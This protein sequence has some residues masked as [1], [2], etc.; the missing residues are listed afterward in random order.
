MSSRV[1]YNN[2]MF[3]F[4]K[5]K[6]KEE[7]TI[8]VLVVNSYSVM[9]AVVRTYHR[10][11]AVAKPI[12]LFSCEEK[13]P[14]HRAS[15]SPWGR[16]GEGM[17][18]IESEI[19]KAL[20]KCRKVHGNYDKLV[21]VIGEPWV[22]N[23]TR[24]M[25][26]EKPKAFKLTQKTIDELL[27]RDARLFEQEALRDYAKEQEWG[28]MYHAQPTVLINGYPA[29]HPV[30][31]VAKS[32]ELHT[33]ISLAPAEVIDSIVEAYADVFHRTDVLFLGTGDILSKFAKHQKNMGVITLGGVSSTCSLFHQGFLD[34]SETIGSGLVEVEESIAY[35]FGVHQSHI[36]SVLRFASDEKLLEHERDVYYKRIEAAYKN[37]SNEI[38]RGMLRIKKQIGSIPGHLW[39][40]ASPSW[41]AILQP[42]IEKDIGVS[43]IIP[44]TEMFNDALIYSHEARIKNAPLALAILAALEK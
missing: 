5:N 20:E 13:I 21:C 26:I 36:T 41:I 42:R 31:M 23:K 28:V 37:L 18:L 19:K 17:N 38:Q 3:S 30:G 27:E 6:P 15:P 44:N 7:R 9:A 34:H 22:M 11:G 10:E 40:L 32:V 35:L 12:V 25:S 29:M 2:Y 14:H 43:V 39:L 33:T 8:C 16:A 24:H 4:L 1:V